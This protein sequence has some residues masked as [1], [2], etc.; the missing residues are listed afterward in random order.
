MLEEEYDRD[1]RRLP[2]HLRRQPEPEAPFSYE[3]RPAERTDVPDIREIYNHYV[4][5]SVV[6]FDDKDWTHAQMVEK[7]DYLTRL[8]LPFLVAVSPT[9]QVLGYGL[10]SPWTGSGGYRYTVESSIYLGQAATGKG[11][12]KVLLQRLIEECEERGIR[13]MVAAI[14]DRGAEGSLALHAKLGFEEVGRMGKVGYKFGRTLGTVYLQKHLAP[15]KRKRS[16]F[17]RRD[18]PSRD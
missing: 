5:N 8:G 15:K 6:T 13:E 1:R 4:R 18:D 16:W 2:R 10:A 17:G 9:G 14:S 3:I 12:G 7:Y 11:L